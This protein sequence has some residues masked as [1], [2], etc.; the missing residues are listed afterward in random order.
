M[1]CGI[2]S[3]FAVCEGGCNPK[4]KH[5]VPDNFRGQ[6]VELGNLD[7]QPPT[8][9]AHC[10]SNATATPCDMR[11]A[12]IGHGCG[13]V[14]CRLGPGESSGSQPAQRLLQFVSLS[15]KF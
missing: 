6:I 3:I 8:A 11:D 13:K 1:D 9:V 15:G 2:R 4:P 10:P 14:G 5:T 7:E 12:S